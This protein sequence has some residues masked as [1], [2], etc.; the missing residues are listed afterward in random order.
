[1][2]GQDKTGPTG[3]GPLT[4]RG[5]GPCG[6]GLKRGYGCGFRRGM[7]RR[8]RFFQESEL[9]KEDEKKILEADLTEIEAEKKEIEKRLSEL[10]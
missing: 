8:F 2:P 5:L 7:G 9:S 10:D 3:M 6:S 1:M 4:G